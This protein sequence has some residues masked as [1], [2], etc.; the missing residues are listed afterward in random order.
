MMMYTYTN[1][2]LP[3]VMNKLYMKTDEVYTYST[4]N[5]DVLIILMYS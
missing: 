3:S 5:I 1:D 4:H 2:M